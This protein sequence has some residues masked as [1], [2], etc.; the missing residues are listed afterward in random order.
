MF[1]L[2]KAIY[3]YSAIPIRIPTAF[4]FFFTELEQIILTSVWN[5]KT[6]QIT[7]AILRKKNKAGGVTIP[8]FKIHYKTV[9]IKIVW[10]QHTSGTHR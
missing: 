6:P 4:F 5:H 1:V 8:D 10:Y 9:V 3:R 7:K 2:P